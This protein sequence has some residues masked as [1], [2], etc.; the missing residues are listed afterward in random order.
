MYCIYTVQISVCFYISVALFYYTLGN[1]SP[2]YR[3]TERCIQLLA[4]LKSTVLQL[5]GPDL[6][7]KNFM[8]DVNK[9]EQVLTYTNA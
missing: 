1:I 7:L 8:K 4:V 5:H 2:K 3:S 6:V 9:L